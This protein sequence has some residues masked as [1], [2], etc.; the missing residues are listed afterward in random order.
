MN[1]KR[2]VIRISDIV[3]YMIRG[4]R[5]ILILAIVGLIVGIILSGIGYIQGNISKE[6]KITSSIAIIAQTGSGN[7]ASKNVNPDKADVELAQ[8][9][10]DSAIYIL[11]SERMLSEAIE[12]A[13]LTGVS[14]KD[15]QKNITFTQYKE[16]QIIETTLFWRSESEGIRIL[17]AINSVSGDVLLETLKIGNVSVVNSPKAGYIVGGNINIST[18]LISAV[19]G[20]ILGMAF[21]LLRLMIAPLLTNVDDLEKLNATEVLGNIAYDKGFSDSSPFASDQSP[22]K[23]DII[24]LAYILENRMKNEGYRKLLLTSTI[25]DEGRT[26]LTVNIAQQLASAGIKTLMI[27]ADFKNPNLSAMFNGSFSYEQS[28]NAVYYGDAD[29]TDAVCH[30]SGCLDLLPC[31]IGE[32]SLSVNEA[33]LR[34][35]DN[36]SEKYDIVLL[37]CAPVGVNAEVISFKSFADV[38]LFVVRYDYADLEDIEKAINRLSGSGVNI[39]GYAVNSVKTFK[40]ILKEAQKLSLFS[41]KLRI[42]ALKKKNASDKEKNKSKKKKKEKEK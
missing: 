14:I 17:S 20:A 40:D 31:M 22:A 10:T 19:I 21:C 29:E 24:S 5:L 36:I 27:D 11:K 8:E 6:Y 2:R 34:V 13:E 12:K 35:I 1:E 41:R 16:T 37:D 3:Y 26:D 30:I 18:W 42:K 33:L 25:K 4:R 15:I 28:L 38:A 7:Y 9:I 23:K 32:R 39:I